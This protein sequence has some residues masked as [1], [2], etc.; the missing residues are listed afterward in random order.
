MKLTDSFVTTLRD[1]PKDALTINHQLLVRAGFV[2][3]LMAG[4][5][6]YLPLGLK[7]LNKISQIVREEMNEIGSTEVLMPIL[8]PAIN[9]KI[10]G[11]W[12]KID[13]LFKVKSRTKRDYALAQSNEETVTPL[14]S[15]F[16]HTYKDLPLSIYHINWKFRDELRSKSGILRG[17]EFLMKDLYSFHIDQEDFDKYYQTA[18]KAYLRV[19][20]RLGLVAKVTEASGGGF[21]E[22]VSYEFEVLTSAGEA[23]ILYCNNCEYCVNID[24]IKKYNEGDNCPLC[25]KAKLKASLAS[26]VGNVFD[27]G[28][29]YTKAFGLTAVNEKGTKVYPIMGCYGIGISRTMGV[30]VEKFHDDK[31]IIWPRE[32]APFDVHLVGLNG[33]GEDLYKKLK[34]NHIDVL[35]DDRDLPAGQKF[36]DADLIGI[37]VRLVVSEKTCE[38]IEFKERTSDK[39]ELLSFDEIIKKLK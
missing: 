6:T 2:R 15:E 30:I 19:F 9:W 39:T 20:E 35:F 11:G 18:K 37:P 33:K 31:G 7:V 25:K 27:L 24:D 10:T 8:H 21:S 36:N 3:Q 34:E 1:A 28:Q 22:K 32:V 13:V 16:I 17:R 23:N 5:Y 26:E 12:D 4:V 29:K 14:T 38:K